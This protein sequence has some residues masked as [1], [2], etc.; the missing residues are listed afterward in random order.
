M[1]NSVLE[2]SKEAARANLTLKG[3][4]ESRMGRIPAADR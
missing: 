1:D 2:K 3:N 4:R